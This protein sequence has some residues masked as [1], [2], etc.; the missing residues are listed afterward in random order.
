MQGIW[1]KSSLRLE[2]DAILDEME[3]EQASKQMEA[4]VFKLSDGEIM[5][6]RLLSLN[7]VLQTQG[8]FCPNALHV[9]SLIVSEEESTQSL[10]MLCRDLYSIRKFLD[11]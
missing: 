11:S 2:H 9:I 8:W 6:V 1:T 10:V 4:H 7:L 3:V 5:R